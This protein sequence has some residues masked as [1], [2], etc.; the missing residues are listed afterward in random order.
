[1]KRALASLCLGGVILVLGACAEPELHYADG[2]SGDF[3]GW[4]GRWVAVNYW[5][6][7]CAPCREEI[8]EL[9]T[10]HQ[11]DD[12]D[13]VGVNFDGLQG[14]KLTDLIA[15]MKIEFPVLLADPRMRWEVEQPGLLPT[16]LLIDPQGRLAGVHRGPQTEADLLRAMNLEQNLE[17]SLDQ[18]LDHAPAAT[19]SD[20]PAAD[21]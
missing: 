13:V 16:T 14:A 19:G 4:N 10:L 8:P 5:A 3:S 7:W 11:R 2:T 12:V 9:N 20:T 17:Q 6:E 1:M 15:R 18:S 21:T